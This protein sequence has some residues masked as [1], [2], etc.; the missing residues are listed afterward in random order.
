MLHCAEDIS[1]AIGDGDK[2]VKK[3]D[4]EMIREAL[5]TINLCV[6]HQKNIGQL[7]QGINRLV[8]RAMLIIS[9][10]AVDDVLS[11]SKL[12]AS[13]LSLKPTACE[14]SKALKTTLK[15][16][17]RRTCIH[18]ACPVLTRWESQFQHEF[19]KERLHF[20]FVVEPGYDSLPVHKVM[21]DMPRVG[22]VLINL[23]VRKFQLFIKFKYP[24][25]RNRN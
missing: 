23:M 8:S 9:L 13:L 11:F 25:H 17:S 16:V 20:S 15:I 5:A 10:L 12:D 18:P 21:A 19:R 3:I 1:E 6:R 2:P 4:I 24:V 22:Q 14:P 7:E